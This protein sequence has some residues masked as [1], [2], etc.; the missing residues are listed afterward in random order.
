[1]KSCLL[2][3]P[4]FVRDIIRSLSSEAIRV[5]QVNAFTT[6]PFKGNPAD[7]VYLPANSPRKAS[8]L[9]L[10][11]IA[12]ESHLP[13]TSF[14]SPL[15][16]NDRC[17]SYSIRWFTPTKEI[18]LCGHG[19]IAAAHVLYNELNE[20]SRKD[21]IKFASKFSGDLEVKVQTSKSSSTSDSRQA[22]Q[23]QH[24]QQH[25]S[26]QSD[27]RMIE[28]VFPNTRL[29]E[30]SCHSTPLSP[31]FPEDISHLSRA[32]GISMDELTSNIIA[33]HESL[34]DL[35][36]EITPS[37]FFSLPHPNND[38]NSIHDQKAKTIV[39]F[40]ALI[41]VNTKRGIIITTSLK[42]TPQAMKQ[43]LSKVYSSPQTFQK[44][45]FLLRMFLPRYGINEDHVSGSAF[46]ALAEYWQDKLRIST[47]QPMCGYQMSGRGGEV[48]VRLTNDKKQIVLGGECVTTKRGQLV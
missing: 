45:D 15:P 6:I 35:V 10:Q 31:L 32:F 8:D 21:S 26:Q 7:V 44:A 24:Q 25:D 37:L 18:E 13:I 17:N 12:T 16:S 4:S 1:M 11:S 39:N 34:Y 27:R 29:F 43:A 22:T 36:L 5:W 28:L 33:V 48:Y 19:T 47:G 40:S 9:W 23:Q 20:V 2:P 14:I 38:S 42:T 41:K 46:C 30:K 3:R